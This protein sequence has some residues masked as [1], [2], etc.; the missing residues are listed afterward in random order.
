MNGPINIAVVRRKHERFIRAN[1]EATSKAAHEAGQD[2]VNYVRKE[3]HF[4]PRTGNL[5]A[6]TDYKL[7]RTSTQRIVK[8]RNAAPYAAAID[9]GSRPHIIAAR[10]AQALRFEV[11]GRIL[12]RKWVR[13]PGTKP[14][15]FLW[16]ATVRGFESLGS[17]LRVEQ[18]RLAKSF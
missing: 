10:R 11:G 13:H 3:P 14:T 6:R 16:F 15:H 5:Q 7:I 9:K 12:F 17:R 18:Q 4:T 1:K 8:V 2:A